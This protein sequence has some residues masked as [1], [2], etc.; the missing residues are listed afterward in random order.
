MRRQSPL[1]SVG[2]S[3]R[4]TRRCACPSWTRCHRRR[5]AAQSSHALVWIRGR[6]LH[7]H[8]RRYHPSGG[9]FQRKIRLTEQ[10]RK[11]SHLHDRTARLRSRNVPPA[12]QPALVHTARCLRRTSSAAR[13][14][15]RRAPRAVL[16]AR[17]LVVP[18]L[19]QASSR[20]VPGRHPPSSSR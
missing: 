2:L 15:G 17:L 8:R 5:R 19:P 3:T 14:R 10:L 7:D 18:Q 1:R 16:R 4:T 11:A 20:I 6:E 12:A 9:H 13:R